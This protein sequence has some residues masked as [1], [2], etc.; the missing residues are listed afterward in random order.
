MSGKTTR[1]SFPDERRAILALTLVADVGTVTHRQLVEQF[2]SASRA[3]DGAFSR[4]VSNAAYAEAGRILV[5]GET[6]RLA[7]TTNIDT[8]FPESLRNL[9][10]PPVALWSAGSYEALRTP[11]VAIVGTR[12]ATS[13]GQ[14]IAREIA[15]A[16][17]RGG[18]CIVS[19]MA[20]GIDACAHRAALDADGRTV[21]VLGTG[22][23]V[24]Y[25]RAHTAMHREIV[26]RGLVLSELAPGAHSNGGS[27]PRRNRIIAGLASLTIVIEAPLLSGALITSNHALE[28]GC[29][30]AA[31]PGPIDSPQCRGSNELIRDGAHAITSIEDALSLVGLGPQ[32]RAAPE[33]RGEDESRVWNALAERASSMDELCARAALPVAH[34]L[35]AVTALE[36]RGLIEC[37][38]T[39]EIRR[40]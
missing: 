1:P 21:A 25:P 12:R 38:L 4:D 32:R 18:A 37:A 28:M 24:A 17:A 5:R 2:R 16:F 14:R 3:L 6:A 10:D 22:A 33:F 20:L 19:G 40:R 23:D 39:G 7:L 35:T 13:Y 8:A 36:L 9:K 30:V 11:V 31:V 29:D 27:F 34:C 26:E 15:S